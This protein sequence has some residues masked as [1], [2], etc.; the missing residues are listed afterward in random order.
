MSDSKEYIS[1]SDESGSVNISEDVIATIAL[2]AM[3]GVDGIGGL[4]NAHGMDIAE[5]LGKKSA[6]KGVK[7]HVEESNIAID[8]HVMSKYGYSVN[9]VSQKIQADVADAV[10]SMTGLEVSAVNVHISGI[11]FE[12]EKQQ[13]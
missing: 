10:E 4:S 3:R 11:T 13:V 5:L 2:E 7:V 8:V 9:E 1:R 12:K 6:T